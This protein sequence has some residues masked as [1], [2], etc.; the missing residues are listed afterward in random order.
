[1]GL[2]R[3]IVGPSASKGILKETLIKNLISQR[4][5]KLWNTRK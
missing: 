5:Q 4:V 1:M 3:V 2:G